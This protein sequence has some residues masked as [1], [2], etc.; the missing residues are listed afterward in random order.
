MVKKNDSR[1]EVNNQK[2]TNGKSHSEFNL[3]NSFRQNF[4]W[5]LY[6]KGALT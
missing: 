6:S 4:Q 2:A 5:I 3:I 1:L